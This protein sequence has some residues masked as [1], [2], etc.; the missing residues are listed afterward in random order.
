MHTRAFDVVQL[1]G[2]YL[3]PYIQTIR[4]Y[5][6][7]KIALRAHN[8]EH[9][10]WLRISN[11]EKSYLKRLYLNNLA[12]RLKN[13]ELNCLSQIDLLIPISARDA[14]I[15]KKFGFSK[16]MHVS[17]TGF[18]LESLPPLYN[19]EKNTLSMGYI[20]SLDWIPN[21]EGIKWFIENVWHKI[22]LDY[23]NII[24]QVAGKNA[25][26]WLKD[27]AGSGM[28]IKIIEAMALGCLIITTSVGAEGLP[29]KDGGH[30]ILAD[31]AE[32]FQDKI[33]Q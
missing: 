22:K 19:Q 30:L 20:G 32:T 1:E 18:D 12:R 25:P 6:N 4:K 10:I 31:D 29:I 24:F 23:P 9:E 33:N 15:F 21:Q 7:A 2:L 27:L 28:R 13:Y 8:I 5:S 16:P 3:A 11:Q 14:E 17:P 26:K